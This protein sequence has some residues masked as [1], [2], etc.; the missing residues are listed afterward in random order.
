MTKKAKE[1]VILFQQQNGNLVETCRVPDFSS[2]V[3][4]V[5]ELNKTEHLYWAV[6]DFD[7]AKTLKGNK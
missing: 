2:A 7:L 5:T 1:Y 3:T 6:P 4:A